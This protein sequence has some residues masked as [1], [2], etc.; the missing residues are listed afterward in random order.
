MTAACFYFDGGGRYTRRFSTTEQARDFAE[1]VL[2]GRAES[3]WTVK[4]D[5]GERR[6]LAAAHS[7]FVVEVRA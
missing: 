3:R 5:Q 1:R 7:C 6:P 2:E 4:T